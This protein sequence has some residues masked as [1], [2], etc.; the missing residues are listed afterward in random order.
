MGCEKGVRRRARRPMD[1]GLR[2]MFLGNS[3][4]IGVV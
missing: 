3:V 1:R 2:A 4:L